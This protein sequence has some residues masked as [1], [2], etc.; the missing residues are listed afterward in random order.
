MSKLHIGIIIFFGSIIIFLGA[1]FFKGAK[2]LSIVSSPSGDLLFNPSEDERWDILILGNRGKG[3]PSGGMLTDSIIV[4]SYEKS[5]G[6]AAIFSIPRDLWVQIPGVGWRKINYAYAVGE[7]KK[8]RGGGLS[9]AK[10]V[11]SQITGLQIDTSIIIDIEGLRRVVDILG[12][13]EVQ[14]ERAFR[15]CFYEYCVNIRPGKNYLNGGETLAYVGSRDVAGADFGRMR[16]QQKVLIAI[17]DKIFSLGIILRPDRIWNILSAIEKH[18]ETDVPP[19]KMATLFN[20][21]S[22][23]EI[24]ETKTV[25]FDTSNVLYHPRTDS[26]GYILLPRAGAGNYYQI[27]R[28]CQNIFEEE[29]E[30][31]DDKNF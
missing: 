26:R 31:K 24:S 29:M 11:V 7:M 20:M 14:E 21:T 3:A 12:G 13:I 25:V 4:L 19:S 18:I 23:L 1:I 9:L 28:V 10:E 2:T 15:T 16:R 22:S 5:T 8:P 27:Q 30:N 6:K 17:K